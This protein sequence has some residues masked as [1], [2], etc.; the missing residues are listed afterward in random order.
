MLYLI[1]IG[2]HGEP[3]GLLLWPAVLVHAILVV[4]L[5]RARSKEEKTPLA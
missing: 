5:F 4:L 1:Y 3:A 2:V